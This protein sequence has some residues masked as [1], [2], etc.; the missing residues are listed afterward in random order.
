[1][2]GTND[3]HVRHFFSDVDNDYRGGL[4]KDNCMN[5]ASW[6]SPLTDPINAF[7]AI[8]L[9]TYTEQAQSVVGSLSANPMDVCHEVTSFIIEAARYHRSIDSSSAN[10]LAS[11][12]VANLNKHAKYALDL[13]FGTPLA[14]VVYAPEWIKARD[15]ITMSGE[16]V[17]A[18][19]AAF[20]QYVLLRI[21]GTAGV[22]MEHDDALHAMGSRALMDAVVAAFGGRGLLDLLNACKPAT[23]DDVGN[24]I[25][26]SACIELALAFYELYR[27]MPSPRLSFP[28]AD[29]AQALQSLRGLIGASVAT[30]KAA[31]YSGLRR[32]VSSAFANSD[33][34][35][36]KYNAP[37]KLYN[38]ISKK[39]GVAKPETANFYAS[40]LRLKRLQGGAW[41]VVP[42]TTPVA[43][44]E[45]ANYRLDMFNSDL[46]V[47]A[48][49]NTFFALPLSCTGIM[50]PTAD[51]RFD[52]M[53]MPGRVHNSP[54]V[55][56]ARYA[57][58]SIYLA[59]YH[60]D[61]SSDTIDIEL[62]DTGKAGASNLTIRGV[63]IG[64]QTPVAK[65]FSIHPEKLI[66]HLWKIVVAREQEQEETTD[67]SAITVLT[68]EGGIFRDVN[69]K[70]KRFDDNLATNPTRSIE[71]YDLTDAAVA[72]AQFT[73]SCKVIG[74]S[75]RSDANS[76]KL[77]NNYII[78]V[79]ASGDA[80]KMA[81]ALMEF[82]NQTFFE[83][84]RKGAS[85]M[86]PQLAVSTLEG[87]GFR[88]IASQ[89]FNGRSMQEF[90][91]VTS[92][93]QHATSSSIT[94]LTSTYPNIK[95][96]LNVVV[97]RAN[98]IRS[99]INE[100]VDD[101]AVGSNIGILN[102]FSQHL[103]LTPYRRNP[104]NIRANA[105]YGVANQISS[106]AIA[107]LPFLSNVL[108][109]T[110][111]LRISPYS[112]LT[113][114]SGGSVTLPTPLEFNRANWQAAKDA[115]PRGK[116]LG[117]NL[118]AAT[119][120][121]LAEIE[122]LQKARAPLMRELM[123]GKAVAN[124][125]GDHSPQV[126]KILDLAAKE[127]RYIE[128]ARDLNGSSHR[129]NRNIAGVYQA[130]DA[131]Q[132]FGMQ[133]APSNKDILMDVAT[134]T[135]LSRPQAQYAPFSYSR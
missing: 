85:E 55:H 128:L 61:G 48:F 52:R 102:E 62:R 127:K 93:T 66:S 112:G 109:G 113:G 97:G 76:A 32:V 64:A 60:A 28:F 25:I 45:R 114:Q 118:I 50:Y 77:C 4:W 27:Q 117:E 81:D 38:R 5:K 71:D 75:G 131:I 70:W 72:K 132:P 59:A 110:P 91:Q 33:Y 49:A 46:G 78:D 108:L 94:T 124:A 10:S 67:N 134:T 34:I 107:T 39:L 17:S 57:L 30:N 35:T 47:P 105:F 133:R 100:G 2:S 96:Y 129:F 92:W 98:S 80:D 73:D 53:Q 95:E 41:V 115:P 121:D 135:H 106:Q 82:G 86:H 16:K 58:R 103:G 6:L 12:G 54:L 22:P 36:L 120:K 79:L 68:N 26:N 116:K 111:L 51:G 130:V 88:K 90:E 21:N 122:R 37:W 101:P 15:L 125:V 3:L 84:A 56:Q 104:Y 65:Y 20:V 63:Y 11:P 69:G 14:T 18:I 9:G 123:F 31:V 29:K 83:E 89:P 74:F 87:F 13:A 19:N 43:E 7:E 42:I 99:S 40:F 119:E 8:R 1:M 23:A 44:S 24:A 126:F